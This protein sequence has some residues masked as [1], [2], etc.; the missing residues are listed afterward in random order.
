ME[1]LWTFHVV[2][3]SVVAI[4]LV[5]LPVP[6][7]IKAQQWATS[8]DEMPPHR[9]SRPAGMVSV[10][11]VFPPSVVAKRAPVLG[12]P[13]VLPTT[14]QCDAVGHEIPPSSTTA[15][16]R[17]RLV[18][19]RPPSVVVTRAPPE[20]ATQTVVDGHDTADGELLGSG[21]GRI[22]S[23]DQAPDAGG[24]APAEAT[25]TMGPRPIRRATVRRV[26]E[27]GA[28]RESVMG[29]G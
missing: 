25:T 6:T 17:C 22:R 8:A 23:I 9:P 2:P 27:R 5:P 7:G 12:S 28:R 26:R 4:T 14:Q 1:R 20:L 29:S 16:G 10:L 24:A 13:L 15:R 18:H 11:H 3:P 19:L 21:P